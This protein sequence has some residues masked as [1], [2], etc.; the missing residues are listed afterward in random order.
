MYGAF[1]STYTCNVS[2]RIMNPNS[3]DQVIEYHIPSLPSHTYR[4]ERVSSGDRC[5]VP[6]P[7]SRYGNSAKLPCAVDTLSTFPL[8][9]FTQS[10]MGIRGEIVVCKNIYS[11]ITVNMHFC[12]SLESSLYTRG[13]DE[14]I[15]SYWSLVQSNQLKCYDVMPSLTNYIILF[16]LTTFFVF[17]IIIL[18]KYQTKKYNNYNKNIEW[19]I[20]FQEPS[21]CS[22]CSCNH[23]SYTFYM[24]MVCL[25]HPFIS[26]FFIGNTA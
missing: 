23:R 8:M 4:V 1:T 13:Y 7:S 20:I 3:T 9:Q 24:R 21:C 17:F 10:Q 5:I 14:E 6:L 26:L 19:M 11:N 25:I 22:S 15:S 2:V 18:F 12:G 16:P